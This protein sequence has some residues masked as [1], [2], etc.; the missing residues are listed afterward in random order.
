MKQ[1]PVPRPALFVLALGLAAAPLAATPWQV[2]RERSVFAVL[3]HRAGIGSRLAHDHLV[4]ARAPSA[5]LDFDPA[6]P[7]AVRF[8]ARANVVALDV[9]PPAERAALSQRLI[10]LGA[11]AAALPEVDPGDREKVRK[12]MLGRDQMAPESFPEVGAELLAL[13]PRGGGDGDGARVAPGW[14][15]RVRL[16]VRGRAVERVIPVRWEVRAGELAAEAL[17]EFRFTEFGIEPYSTMLGAIRNDDRF[18][19]YVVLVAR[20]DGAGGA[21]AGSTAAGTAPA[22]AD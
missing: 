21:A 12:A 8:S 4:V 20:P 6:R 13:A 10:E 7:E 19:L 17:G 1:R 5:Q 15:A 18:H 2:D 3:T 11:L 9:D 22:A 16:T 14:S